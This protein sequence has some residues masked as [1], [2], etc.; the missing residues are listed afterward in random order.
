[1]PTVSEEQVKPEV[2][3]TLAIISGKEEGGIRETQR[4]FEDLGMSKELKRA[5]AASF[6]KTARHFNAGATV[7]RLECQKL[8]TVRASIKLVAKKASTK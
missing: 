6:E 5:C 3:H 7:T 8:L 1:M 4:L 2:V